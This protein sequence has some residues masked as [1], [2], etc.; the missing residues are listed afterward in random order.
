LAGASRVV[1]FSENK[2]ANQRDW[3]RVSA[4]RNRFTHE[5][6]DRAG[7]RLTQLTHFASVDKNGMFGQAEI[8]ASAF[9][10]P[11]RRTTQQ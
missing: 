3:I 4:D 1:F 9:I 10:P 6:D 5:L 8:T 2:T 11:A 7:P